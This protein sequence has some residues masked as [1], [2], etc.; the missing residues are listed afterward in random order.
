[1]NLHPLATAPGGEAAPLTEFRCLFEPFP[2][3]KMSKTPNFLRS[4]LWRA[5]STFLSF[6]W[7]RAQKQSIRES[8]RLTLCSF[9]HYSALRVNF[10]GLFCTII[11]ALLSVT[12]ESWVALFHDFYVSKCQ[13]P[14]FSSLAP[15]AL[16]RH[17][18]TCLA[19]D[20]RRNKALVSPFV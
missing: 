20:V 10:G 6:Y 19:G 4:R 5:R 16:A 8:V 13:M 3:L 7:G 18:L 14:K 1:M 15:L 17:V 2:Y 9:W 11:L 12:S